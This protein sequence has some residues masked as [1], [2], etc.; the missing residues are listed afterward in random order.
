MLSTLVVGYASGYVALVNL[1]DGS[2]LDHVHVHG[3]V[4]DLRLEQNRLYVVSELGDH[5]VLEVGF[6]QASLCQVL[7]SVWQGVP[8]I[9]ERGQPVLRRPPADHPCARVP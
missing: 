5:V 6:L 8:V 7:Q 1:D 9:W 3:P 2:R 4:R